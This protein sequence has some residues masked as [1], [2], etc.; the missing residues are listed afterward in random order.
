MSAR[1]K[2]GLLFGMIVLGI[3][4]ACVLLLTAPRLVA[5]DVATAEVTAS[6]SL[7]K[8]PDVVR[9]NGDQLHQ[10]NI[11][12][13]R[14][15]QFSIQKIAVGQIAFNEDASTV[16]LTPFSGRVTRLIAKIGDD[17]KRGEALFEIDSP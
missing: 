12:P 1:A 17:V 10:L 2:S 15:D 4:L 5:T 11:E 6:K 9:V 14:V 7:P 16:V 13:A 8:N 3:A